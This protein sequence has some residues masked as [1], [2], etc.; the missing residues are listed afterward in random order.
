MAATPHTLQKNFEASP[1]TLWAARKWGGKIIIF[2]DFSKFVKSL[3]NGGL[4]NLLVA[5]QIL[6]PLGL[7]RVATMAKAAVEAV[8]ELDVG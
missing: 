4:T 5:E 6:L 2:D 3:M 8:V 1:T 7:A